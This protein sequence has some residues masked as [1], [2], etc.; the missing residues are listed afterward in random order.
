MWPMKT[1]RFEKKATPFAKYYV[2]N[3]DGVRKPSGTAQ[4]CT[5]L[6]AQGMH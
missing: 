2:L 1:K 3:T 4:L 6:Q 5:K